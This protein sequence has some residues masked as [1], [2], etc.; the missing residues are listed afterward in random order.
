MT[1]INTA[2]MHV[3]MEIMDLEVIVRMD[4]EEGVIIRH[5][6]HADSTR[7]FGTPS[8]VNDGSYCAQVRQAM[9]PLSIGKQ[10]PRPGMKSRK[11]VTII[12]VQHV[13]RASKDILLLIITEQHRVHSVRLDTLGRNV[14]LKTDVL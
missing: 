1:R 3:Q 11:M 13:M 5:P 12:L 10:H 8:P 2:V 7:D 6:E 4:P 9:A 14:T